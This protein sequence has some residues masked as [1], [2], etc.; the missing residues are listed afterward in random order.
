MGDDA[1]PD[2][3]SRNA[4]R[5]LGADPPNWVPR[6]AGVDADVVVVGGG[7]CGVAIAFAL[8]RAG[9]GHVEVIDAAEP[10]QAGLWLTRARMPCLR[11]PKT[12]SG[13]ELNIAGLGFQSWYEALHGVE[14]FADLD[15]IPRTTW[16]EYLVW[17]QKA[18]NVPVRHRTRLLE[19]EP[20]E[21]FLRLHL[22]AEGA[23]KVSTARKIVL[24]TGVA[25]CGAPYVPAVIADHL[26][27]SHY[28]HTH[29]DIPCERLAGRSVGILGAAASAFDAA[30]AALEAGAA[31]VH[32]FCRRPDIARTAGGRPRGYPGA[33]ENFCHLPDQD[34]WRL[35]LRQFR[36]YASTS[37]LDSIVRAARWENF[38]LHLGAPWTDVRA[39]GSTI[40]V[41][42]GGAGYSFDFAI[43]GTGYRANPSA[44]PELRPLAPHIALWRDRYVPAADEQ[45][46]A[47]GLYPYLGAGYEFIEKARGG[48]PYLKDIH[49]FNGGASLSFGRPIGDIPSL[50]TEIPRLVAAISRDFF[51]ADYPQHLHRMMSEPAPEF[52]PEPYVSSVRMSPATPAAAAPAGS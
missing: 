46:A 40:T 23:A 42:A 33:L 38:H 31:Q 51:F 18:V 6:Q 9:I 10:G 44:R 14:G 45:D 47:F 27:R 15:R 50:R 35:Q 21:G 29:D 41:S 11:T 1:G 28:A 43:A 36:D 8:R 17:F 19:V 2:A 24:A 34:R 49:C 39:N 5:L 7:Q 20:A 22:D 30:N 37:P 3:A 16:A 32:L 25:G 13:P 4:L 12:I 26:P 52:G 48:A